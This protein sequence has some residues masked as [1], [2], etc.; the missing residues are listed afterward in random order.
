MGLALGHAGHR[1]LE[2]VRMQVG[3]AG[4]HALRSGCINR[5]PRPVQP[6]IG[7]PD[8]G[9]SIAVH[10]A[11]V[12]CHPRAGDLRL[13]AYNGPMTIAPAPDTKGVP[14]AASRNTSGNTPAN[15]GNLWDGLILGASLAT[16]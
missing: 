2:R 8:S 1:A 10:P 3:D 13:V 5:W 14:S 16:L 6:S 7:V 9:R 12:A 4:Y 11:I 15:T